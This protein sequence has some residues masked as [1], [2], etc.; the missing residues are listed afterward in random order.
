MR[1]SDD[2]KKRTMLVSRVACLGKI[3]HRPLGYSGPLSRQFLGYQAM[4][5]AVRSNLRNLV[6]VILAALLLNG[7]A[8]RDRND[9]VE[10]SLG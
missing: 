6:E 10:L 7:D 4:I 2:D 3:G 5:S 9:W 8:D 1:G